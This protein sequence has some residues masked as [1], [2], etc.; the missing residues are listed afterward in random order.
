[1]YIVRVYSAFEYV[2]N[3]IRLMPLISFF[4]SQMCRCDLAY[5]IAHPFAMAVYRVKITCRIFAKKI[6][7]EQVLK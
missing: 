2:L 5:R 1:M 7:L 6:K 3:H 4:T